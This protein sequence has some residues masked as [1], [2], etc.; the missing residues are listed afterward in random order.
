MREKLAFYANVL[1]RA[2]PRIRD[3]AREPLGPAAGLPFQVLGIGAG[4]PDDLP[5]LTAALDRLVNA[6]HP[7]RYEHQMPNFMT[8]CGAGPREVYGPELYDRVL[9]VKQE[10]DP[11]DLFRV[12]V[13]VNFG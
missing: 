8:A 5:R 6:L 7:W 1:R 3:D 12:N 4:G 11:D 9:A 10:Y 13:N 2:V